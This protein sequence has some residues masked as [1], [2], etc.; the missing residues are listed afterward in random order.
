M[1]W[2]IPW[3][4][5]GAVICFFGDETWRGI[6]AGRESGVEGDVAGYLIIGNGIVD[7]VFGVRWCWIVI[8]DSD[9]SSGRLVVASPS[10]ASVVGEQAVLSE[11][12]GEAT[13][14]QWV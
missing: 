3:R 10:P 4:E 9:C 5:T 8:G 14:Q 1:V 12:A 2:L 13:R 11:R 6:L 7:A